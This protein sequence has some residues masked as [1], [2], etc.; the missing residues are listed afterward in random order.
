MTV[1]DSAPSGDRTSW[2]LT[3]RR[4]LPERR[5]R[6]R[7][8]APVAYGDPRFSPTAYP[9]STPSSG[10]CRRS[11]CQP[12]LRHRRHRSPAQ[13]MHAPGRLARHRVDMNDIPAQ[14][15][16][17]SRTWIRHG[18]ETSSAGRASAQLHGRILTHS[19]ERVF[20]SNGPALRLVA[21]G[22]S[23]RRAAI[24]RCR[25]AT[26]PGV[27]NGLRP[28][29]E[30]A[31]TGV[32]VAPIA[33]TAGDARDL[34]RLA[35]TASAGTGCQQERPAL[36]HAPRWRVPPRREKADD[37]RRWP[38]RKGNGRKVRENPDAPLVTRMMRSPCKRG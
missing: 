14:T 3:G 33:P 10:R 27:K 26:H 15:R 35:L 24:P 18:P 9:R 21:A 17:S 12:A 22:P 29:A 1:H 7:R 11:R 37:P 32:A 13:H 8:F 30:N 5:A 25:G 20:A 16:D 34:E 6:G 2:T 36:T 23:D 19:S 28:E 31:A 38:F 4:P